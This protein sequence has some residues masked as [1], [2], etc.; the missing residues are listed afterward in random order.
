M[1]RSSVTKYQSS[2]SE[3]RQLKLYLLLFHH[4]Y[5]IAKGWSKQV[6]LPTVSWHSQ[7]PFCYGGYLLKF[8]CSATWRNFL[9]RTAD[10]S[11]TRWRVAMI[12]FLGRSC[13]ERYPLLLFTKT[14]RFLI[15]N[16]AC[17][18]DNC[19]D[20]ESRLLPVLMPIIS[21]PVCGLQGYQP[22]GSNALPSHP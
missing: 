12:L 20:E 5:Q 7:T 14:N 10:R 11:K 22:P 18:C 13:V 2:P 1:R 4:R 15:L 19:S 16:S 3:S 17:F 9:C 6:G 21:F 8:R